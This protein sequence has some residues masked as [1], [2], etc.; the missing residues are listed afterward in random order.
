MKSMHWR[1]HNGAERQTI[2]QSDSFSHEN[3]SAVILT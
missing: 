2:G 1:G 3:E